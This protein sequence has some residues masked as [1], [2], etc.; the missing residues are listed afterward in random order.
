MST[1]PFG[2]ILIVVLCFAAGAAGVAGFWLATEA[3]APGTS[4][5]VQLFTTAWSI[6]FVLTGVLLWRRSSFASVLFLVAMGFPVYLSRFVVPGGQAFL[7]A[8][9][10]FSFLGVL[11]Y[12]YLRRASFSEVATAP[13]SGEIT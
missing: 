4:P 7:P 2:V 6:T 1:R 12:M 11:G 8:L 13:G 5:L 9:I 3:R 10:V